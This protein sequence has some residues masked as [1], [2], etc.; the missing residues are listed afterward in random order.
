MSSFI[1]IVVEAK[2]LYIKNAKLIN[3]EFQMKG[4]VLNFG[5]HEIEIRFVALKEIIAHHICLWNY[6]I[7]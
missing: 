5:F 4:S 7:C 3:K 2:I 1:Y 6:I